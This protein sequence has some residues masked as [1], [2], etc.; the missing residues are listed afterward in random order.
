MDKKFIK[1][2]EETKEILIEELDEVSLKKRIILTGVIDRVV[3]TG[4][5]TIFE[6]KDGTGSLS[7]KGFI[8]P[9]Q[10]AYPEINEG[11]YVR[12][13]IKLEEFNGSIE[14][15][16]QSIVKKDNESK[17][18]IKK[19]IE[20]REREKSKVKPV[21]FLV[22][23]VILQKLR[24]K[25]IAAAT[26][27]RLAI[28]QGR[29]IIIRHHSDT[30]GYSAGF[31]LERAILPLIEKQHVSEKASWE[32][33][34]RAPSVA[35]YYEI[36]DSI[37]DT[38][39]SLKNVAKF[40]N[41]MP[42]VIIVDNGSTEADLMAIKQ[43]KVHGETFIVVDHHQFDKD[44]ISDEVLVH[45]NPFLVGESGSKMSA[46]MLCAE[47][48]RFVNPNVANVEQIPALAGLA[49]RI[50]LEN[51]EGV[52]KYLKIA[53]EK[54]YSKELLEDISLVIEYVSAKIRFMEVREYIEVLFGEPRDKQKALVELLAPYIKEL[55][56]KGLA[57]GKAHAKIEKINDITLQ[58]VFVEETYP[59]FGFFPKPGRSVGLLH[60]SIQVEKKL[61]KVISVGVMETSMTFRATTNSN[62][63]VHELITFLNKKVPEA[64]VEGGGHKNAG[65]ITFLPNRKEKMLE[66][67]KEFIKGR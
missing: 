47:L 27:I 39:L 18:Q 9:G 31:A 62:F 63:S 60:D 30:D 53:K 51:K 25:F 23:S 35:P 36:D 61:D 45:I 22:D 66:L 41:K 24:D 29:S 14:G 19:Q 48:A 5:P 46:G 59:G 42:L 21:E 54:G 44:V 28:F 67:V 52:E 13:I 57:I 40:S 64:F 17:L 34:M 26:E 7:L 56:Q 11:D 65:S 37:R 1:K 10:R 2:Q 4:G 8:G 43:G 6:I 38:A 50:F 3:Q 33:F 58:T 20:H 32:F 12:T 16:I 49:D 55:D 15:D